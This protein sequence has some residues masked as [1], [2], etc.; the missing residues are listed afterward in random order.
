MA[1]ER[2]LGW[3]ADPMLRLEAIVPPDAKRMQVLAERLRLS[4][5]EAERLRLWAIAPKIEPGSRERDLAKK[6]YRCGRQPIG[7]GRGGGDIPAPTAEDDLPDLSHPG[8]R[9]D[10][11]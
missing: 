6:L 5:V 3:A 11:Q 1:A 7:D 10:I 9:F 2:D 4:N 8:I